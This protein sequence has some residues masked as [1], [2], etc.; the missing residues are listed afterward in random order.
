MDDLYR[1]AVACFIPLENNAGSVSFV[2]CPGSVNNVIR[3]VSVEN[4]ISHVL[5]IYNNGNDFK[6]IELEHLIL[7]CLNKLDLTFS[8]PQAV[9]TMDAA[10]PIAELSHGS[11]VSLFHLIPG[12]LPKLRFPRQLGAACGEL[13]SALG[14][15]TQQLNAV[16]LEEIRN[17]GTPP[18]YALYRAHHSMSKEAF[19]QQIST[20]AYDVCR[21]DITYLADAIIA[22]EDKL[23][24]YQELDL[25]LQLIHGDL[26]YDNIL[27]HEDGRVSGI[28]DFEFIA[29]DWRAMEL[30]I[31]LSK[32]ASEEEPLSYFNEFIAGFAYSMT[33]TQ[34]ECQSLPMLIV[35]RILSNVVFFVGRAMVGEDK[36][37]T[38]TAGRAA[39]YRHRIEWILS[40]KSEIVSSCMANGLCT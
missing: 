8:I 18:Y 10:L 19:A 30:A 6:K 33:L 4:S 39:A 32:Y 13:S 22:L 2:P 11:K 12:T 14:K 27:C 35:L 36:H 17:N 21:E 23:S 34:S 20:S 3:Y 16:Q 31:C 29:M 40:N 1:E 15:V 26:H 7:D 38:L 9:S 37:E 5:R 24:R 28:L 25:P